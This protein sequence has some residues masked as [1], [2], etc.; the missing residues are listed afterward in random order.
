MILCMKLE[1]K[2]WKEDWDFLRG[3]WDQYIV[4]FIHQFGRKLTS[5]VL[6]VSLCAQP[7]TAGVKLATFHTER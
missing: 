5:S 7:H 2:G 1:I 4:A 6:S 3:V